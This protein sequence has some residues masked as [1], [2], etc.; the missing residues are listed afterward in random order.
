MCNK[1]DKNLSEKEKRDLVIEAGMQAIPWVGGSL[2]TLYFGSKQERQFK[3][4]KSFYEEVA[5]EINNIKDQITD[6]DNQ[7]QEALIAILEELNEKVE[8][9][10]IEEKRNY[11]KIYL[12]NT[13]IN[14]INKG[15][16]DERKYFLDI[17]SLMSLLECEILSLLYNKNKSVQ[18]RNIN[19][20][21]VQKYAIVG[22]VGRLKTYGF[23]SSSQSSFAIG[24]G[25]DNVLNEN[26]KVSSFGCC[27]CNFCLAI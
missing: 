25:Q 6:I 15:N 24:G 19:K 7:D 17:L 11:L 27:F 20:F 18:I 16:Y 26:V 9:E 8:R 5:E 23:L 10:Q 2:A 22:A 4:L 14:P 1:D 12:E 13:L 21:G 3:R